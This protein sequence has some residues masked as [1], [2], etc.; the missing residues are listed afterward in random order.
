MNPQDKFNP[1][2]VDCNYFISEFV[3]LRN[4]R[5]IKAGR[6]NDKGL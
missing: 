6:F 5:G 4:L 1:N 3:K 2:N